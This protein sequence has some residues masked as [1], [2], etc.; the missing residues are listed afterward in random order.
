MLFVGCWLTELT[1]STRHDNDNCDLTIQAIATCWFC[2]Y[3]TQVTEAL[4]QH[5]T[6]TLKRW[7][8]VW[9]DSSAVVSVHCCITIAVV[10]LLNTISKSSACNNAS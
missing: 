3:D 9:S 5:F 10:R 4:L 1:F 6:N 7:F 8:V 2:G